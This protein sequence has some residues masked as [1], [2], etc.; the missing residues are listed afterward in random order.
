MGS[1][2]FDASTNIC[3]TRSFDLSGDNLEVADKLFVCKK[4]EQQQQE[5]NGLSIRAFCARH[6]IAKTT[7]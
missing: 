3:W 5:P 7:F 1:L 4:F 6:E 2:D